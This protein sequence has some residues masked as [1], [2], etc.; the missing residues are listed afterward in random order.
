[1]VLMLD[2]TEVKTE[3]INNKMYYTHFI[4]TYVLLFH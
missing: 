1:M 4:K 2:I 3:P